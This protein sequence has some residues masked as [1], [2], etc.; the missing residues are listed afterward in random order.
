MK[1]LPIICLLAI[2]CLSVKAQ[3]TKEIDQFTHDTTTMAQNDTLSQY[4]LR[5]K[6]GKIELI[7]PYL[8]CNSIKLNKKNGKAY[9]FMFFKFKAKDVLSIS[10][11]DSVTFKTT[12][13][14]VFKA[15][16][17]GKDKIYTTLDYI[18]FNINLNEGIISK[19]KSSDI[20]AIRFETSKGNYDYNIDENKRKAIA[21]QISSLNQ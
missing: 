6:K 2:L 13:D 19:F 15:S 11:S 5:D 8:T 4:V 16:Y 9:Q 14:S 7:I 20:I 3:T 10:H 18:S 21:K 17:M 1:T 12:G